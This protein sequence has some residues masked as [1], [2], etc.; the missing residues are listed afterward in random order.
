MKCKDCPEFTSYR[1]RYED[2]LE[3]EDSG[4]C[5]KDQEHTNWEE[6]CR[7]KHNVVNINDSKPHQASEVVCLK[8]LS[9]W[10][11]V[12][13]TTTQLRQLEC[14]NCGQ[15]YVIETGELIYPADDER[16]CKKY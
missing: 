9:R 5:E 1:S 14:Q 10:I 8:C 13:P 7:I 16:D 4:I 11:A 3:D 15:G 6:E 12:R 2:P